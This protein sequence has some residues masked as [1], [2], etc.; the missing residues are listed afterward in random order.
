VIVGIDLDTVAPT[1]EVTSSPKKIW[2][3]NNKPRTVTITVKAADDSGEAT[4]E[5]RVER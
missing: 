2:R 5:V 3:P 4:A 1:I